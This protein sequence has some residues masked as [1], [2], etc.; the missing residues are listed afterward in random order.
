MNHPRRLGDL[1]VQERFEFREGQRILQRGQVVHS[2]DAGV[3]VRL[4]PLKVDQT[5]YHRS[6]PYTE[7]WSGEVRVWRI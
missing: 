6:Q 4:D 5:R 3:T 2:S 7:T 1:R